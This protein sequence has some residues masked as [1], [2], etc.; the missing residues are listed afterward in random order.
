MMSWTKAAFASLPALARQ[1]RTYFA[2][3]LS[4]GALPAGIAGLASARCS[5]MACEDYGAS[6]AAGRLPWTRSISPTL[7]CDMPR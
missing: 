1:D 7:L 2:M 3:T 6:S 4:K 5:A